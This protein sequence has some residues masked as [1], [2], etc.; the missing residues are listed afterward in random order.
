M[1]QHTR[2]TVDLGGR[3]VYGEDKKAPY[4]GSDEFGG[5][6]GAAISQM[7]ASKMTAAESFHRHS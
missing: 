5:T 1:A 7:V 3:F 6:R 4:R 2:Q